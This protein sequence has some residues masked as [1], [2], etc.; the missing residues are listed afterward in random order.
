MTTL[1]VIVDEM[2]NP[3]PGGSS[4][5]SEELSRQLIAVAPPGCS[6]EGIVSAST[7]AEYE[8]LE[9][10]LP[11][12]GGMYKSA[13]ARRELMLAWQH[14]FTRLPRGGMVHSPSLLAPLY[15]HDRLNNLGEQTIVT[16]HDALPWTHPE[17]LG[18]RVAGW[19]VSMAKRA[20][21]YADAVVVPTHAVAVRLRE[22]LD[23]GDRIRVIGG[24]ASTKLTRPVDADERATRLGL[25]GRYLLAFGGLEPVRG[26]DQIIRALAQVH[27]D[28]TLLFVGA[29]NPDE[30]ATIATEAGVAPDRVRSLGRLGDAD[31][32]V[33]L[34]RAAALVM[35]S[36]EDGFG[37]PILEAFTFGTPVIHSDAAA[38]VEVAADAGVTVELA[39]RAS[40][41]GRLADAIRAVLDDPAL[42]DRLG[43]Y[44]ADRAR[45]YS[46]RNSAEKVWQLHAD[47]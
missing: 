44:G 25:Y 15:R 20:H 37:L 46:W 38:L 33:A 11:G 16:I 10:R 5:Y 43:I 29:V 12:L 2:L 19:H 32:S 34:D 45:A 3:L 21:R 27:P 6:V 9:A 17:S 36:E 39:D 28:V 22:F 26:N 1:R 14:G 30:L 24:A 35:A 4:R 40:F 47:L 31:L 8:S 18:A 7:E 13:L 41:P 42:A 23:F